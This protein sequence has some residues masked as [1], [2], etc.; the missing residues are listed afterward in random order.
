M[1]SWMQNIDLSAKGV[2]FPIVIS[3]ALFLYSLIMPKREI[4]WVD[5]YV[6]FSFIGY[7][8]WVINSLVGR[9][10]DL[11]DLGD[12]NVTGI[13]EFVSYSII[14]SA[15]AVIYV[16]YATAKNR[17]SLVVLFTVISTLIEWGMIAVDYLHIKN[18][19]FFAFSIILYFIVFAFVLPWHMRFIK[20]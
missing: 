6:T 10:F 12:K 19:S 11:V 13:G 5:Y 4:N 2:W 18:W 16:N 17:W 7:I 8:A 15:L 9:M 20:R 3:G 14:P 1:N